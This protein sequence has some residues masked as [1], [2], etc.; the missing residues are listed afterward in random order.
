[1]NILADTF[2]WPTPLAIIGFAAA[3]AIII[4]AAMGY[5]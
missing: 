5:P 2:N 3:G 1:M 4:W